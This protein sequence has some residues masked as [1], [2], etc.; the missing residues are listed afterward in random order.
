MSNRS[1]CKCWLFSANSYVD[2]CKMRFFYFYPENSHCDW[3]KKSIASTHIFTFWFW[4]WKENL[5]AMFLCVYR[6]S[7]LVLPEVESRLWENPTFPTPNRHLQV[8]HY[9][10]YLWLGQLF[11]YSPSPEFVS[12]WIS[13]SPPPKPKGWN[14]HEQAQTKKRA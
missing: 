13:L 2:N 14:S 6:T 4:E 5:P 3:S 12:L 7:L 11:E 8:E 1:D 10:L 9:Q